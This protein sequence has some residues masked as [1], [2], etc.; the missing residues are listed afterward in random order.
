MRWLLF[1]LGLAASLHLPA[2]LT[3]ADTARLG[4]RVGLTGSWLS[5]NVNRLLVVLSADM[6][7]QR[8]GWAFRSA[9]TWQ[10]GSFGGYPTERDLFARQFFY[11]RPHA[12]LYPYAM[13]WAETNLRRNLDFR[14]QGGVGASAVLLHAERIHL[15]ASATLS[16]ESAR[17]G[18]V[19][20]SDTTYDGSRSIHVL[21]GT[22]RV[23]G[24]IQ[25][26]KD[27]RCVLR[28]EGWIQPALTQVSNYR[29]HADAALDWPLR[30][31]VALRAAFNYNRESVV[32]VGVLP[33]D[34]FL[35]FG[36]VIGSLN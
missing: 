29:L 33:A 36:F 16:A 13:V 25:P 30:R 4:G 27:S 10:Q 18:S 8:E 19:S 5:G 6:V 14:V 22:G 26:L 3:E 32:A 35:T 2:Q 15:K 7:V 21:R 23:F 31:R 11:L 12:R 20:F 17:F 28:F 24:R 1:L 34:S 9:Q